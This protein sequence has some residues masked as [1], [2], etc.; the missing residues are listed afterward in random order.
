MTQQ[1]PIL[2]A[3]GARLQLGR[4]I[5]R[6]GE[7]DVYTLADRN[8][9]AVKFYTVRD[10]L[11]RESK[12]VTMVRA[13]LADR[14]SFVAFPLNIARHRDGRFAGFVMRM[15]S[16]HRP[17]HEL[18]SPK[19][20]KHNFP[21]ADYR[22]LIRSAA[23]VARAV[24]SVHENGCVIGDINHSGI[25]I[26][27]QALAALIDAD[28]FQVVEQNERHLCLVGVP[29]YTPPELQGKP[30]GSVIRT[31]DHDAFGLATVI[32]QLLFMGR[33][34]FMGS[35]A[36]G[37]MPIERAIA[38]HRFA[39]SQRRDVGM[40]PP[41]GICTLE[42][43]PSE[44]RL[45]FETAFSPD[46]SIS[47]P[48]ADQWASLLNGLEHSLRRCSANSLH[49]YPAAAS[50]CPWCRYENQN[51]LILFIPH[52]ATTA[53]GT[54][55]DP[56]AAAFNLAVIWAAIESVR[57]PEPSA[58]A[59]TLP[60]VEVKPSEE[61]KK[62]RGEAALNLAK[63]IGLFAVA[64]AVLIGAPYLWFVWGGLGVWGFNLARKR[65]E[66]DGFNRRYIAAHQQW[67]K[68]LAD[69][70]ARCGFDEVKS[71]KASLLQ[72]KT[73]YERIPRDQ[74]ERVA[75]YQKKRQRIQL[76]NYLDRFE[77]R[78]ARIRGIG[79]AKVAAL[80]SY[81]IET[82]AD[83]STAAI[84]R[85]PGFG[86]ATTAAI[87]EWRRRLEGR[88]VYDPKP[89]AVD[90]QELRMIA[91]E[92]ANKGADLRRKLISGANDLRNAIKTIDARFRIPD[93]VLGR[94]NYEKLRAR[95]DLA[96]LGLPIPT[97]PKLA[98]VSK[99]ASPRSTIGSRWTPPGQATRMPTAASAL[100]PSCPK[101][102][103]Q[104]VKR[105]ARRGAN[106]GGTFWGC[107]RFPNCRGTRSR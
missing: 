100:A 85:V 42:D 87:V 47:R 84:L 26:S 52:F 6:G 30:L 38:E 92:F 54:A 63:G 107:S 53:S 66:R 106:A 20:R 50:A 91:A 90:Q 103:G 33:H 3:D 25:L 48:T 5:G 27:D 10:A 22:F 49:Y 105:T 80:R 69:W 76:E 55:S 4:R 89:N 97:V 32:F 70:Q 78:R 81:G 77:M 36:K 98:T 74:Q 102:G 16:G 83:V 58:Y 93:P 39:F 40:T 34:P 64:V 11:S 82:A 72:A 35:Y 1:V 96:A 62:A 88:F 99:P 24:G 94:A 44:L 86:P 19:A 71:L 7:G 8:D 23:N 101:C 95:A 9:L 31:P 21:K 57:I 13:R 51:G 79:T 73:A 75:S 2:F 59:P 43:F 46:R 61:V 41:P 14:S 37:E 15:V 68:A 104:M 65:P 45:A 12:I 18:Y 67:D 60:N 29:E 28:S 56:G 17:L